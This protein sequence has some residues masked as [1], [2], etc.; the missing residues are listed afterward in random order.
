M[1][2]IRKSSR[3]AK[4]TWSFDKTTFFT[5][6][7]FFVIA[8]VA[9]TYPTIDNSSN[10]EKYDLSDAW[11]KI[12]QEKKGEI[13]ESDNKITCVIGNKSTAK[14]VYWST[15]GDAKAIKD[16]EWIFYSDVKFYLHQTNDV[17]E[18][19]TFAWMDINNE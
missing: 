17:L 14:R 15:C 13:I 10:Q 2:T 12:C 19:C 11:T 1:K 9:I 5:V 8:I 18:D 4:F 16:I 6:V 7:S 3:K